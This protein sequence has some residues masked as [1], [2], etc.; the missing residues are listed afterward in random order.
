MCHSGVRGPPLSVESF[1]FEE[2]AQNPHESRSHVAAL[3]LALQVWKFNETPATSLKP[4]LTK[5]FQAVSAEKKEMVFFT[6]H[7]SHY[8]DRKRGL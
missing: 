4:G 7:Y 3:S 1:H 2:S 6:V 8:L 5:V